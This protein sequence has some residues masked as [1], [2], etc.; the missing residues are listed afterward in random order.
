MIHFRFSAVMN[1]CFVTL[2]YGTGLPILFFISLFA[3]IILYF[4]ERICI[5]YYYKQPPMFGDEMT[6][7]VLRILNWAPLLYMIIG[8]WMLG[9]KQ[10]FSNV[11]FPIVD[12]HEIRKSGH[13]M[14]YN[15]TKIPFD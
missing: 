7:N 12:S 1:I 11:T 6:V 2:M 14:I 15:L 5:F 9:N 3:F 10:I 8:F 13:L 4:V